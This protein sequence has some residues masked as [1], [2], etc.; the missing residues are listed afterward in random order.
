MN[1]IGFVIKAVSGGAHDILT[2]NDGTWKKNVVDPRDYLRMFSALGETDSTLTAISFSQYGCYIMLLRPIFGRAGDCLSAWLFIP[3]NIVIGDDSIF[4]VYKYVKEVLKLSS[5]EK[6]ED[7]II[8]LFDKKYVEKEYYSDYL[9]SS[10]ELFAFRYVNDEIQLKELLGRKRYQHYYSKYKAIFLLQRDSDVR[11]NSDI[12]NLT[13]KELEEYCI[14]M[15]PTD[16]ELSEMGQ[17]AKVISRNGKTFDSPVSIK[18]GSCVELIARRKGFEDLVLRPFT[19]DKD[20]MPFP[21]IG[22]LNWKK[23]IDN[24]FFDI[25]NNDG[26]MVEVEKIVVAGHDITN[27]PVPLSEEECRHANIQIT[28]Y[29]RYEP[30]NSTEDLLKLREKLKITLHRAE[31]SDKYKIILANGKV[32]EMTLKSKYLDGLGKS[33]LEGY[34]YDDMNRTLYTS[35]RYKI[36]YGSYGI[37]TVLVLFLLWGGLSVMD[38]WYDTHNFKWGLPPWEDINC[39]T[40]SSDVDSAACYV[41]PDSAAVAYLNNNG[42]WKKDSLEKYAV[43]QNLYTQ[44][45]NY[46]FEDLKNTTI[47]SC[48][49]YNEIKSVAEQAFSMAIRMSEKYPDDGT[50]TIESWIKKVRHEIDKANTNDGF[51]EVEDEKSSNTQGSLARKVSEKQNKQ[52]KSNPRE[53]TK[54]KESKSKDS[55]AAK[56]TDK[57]SKAGSTKSGDSK[58]GGLYE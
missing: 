12:E 20:V 43:T 54:G 4:E 38:T 57:K 36:K 18:K 33:P 26:E 19:V 15:P 9:P 44:L 53:A 58:N 3:N 47:D 39:P 34:S 25:R 32:A 8:Q 16:R 30:W 24:S 49:R 52:L 13:D 11:A 7:K 22:H 56:K 45:I 1:K 10:G 51:T 5:I 41:T 55:N 35:Y 40:D 27:R 17:G 31:K 29:N 21:H 14:L 42:K 6:I 48:N 23:M 46:Q 50:I 2:C 37:L 28:A